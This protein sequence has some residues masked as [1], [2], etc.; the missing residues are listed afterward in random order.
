[1]T[2]FGSYAK[3]YIESPT[4]RI[5][6]VHWP[7]KQP[8][9]LGSLTL[10]Y[11]GVYGGLIETAHSGRGIGIRSQPVDVIPGHST[12]YW[13]DPSNTAPY[14]GT[15]GHYY[16]QLAVGGL[17]PG[18]YGYAAD[19]PSLIF[20]VDFSVT[21]NVGTFDIKALSVPVI[22]LV[23]DSYYLTIGIFSWTSVLDAVFA[24]GRQDGFLYNSYAI[25]APADHIYLLVES[26]TK[27]TVNL[28]YSP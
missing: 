28:L 18:Y 22:D 16:P 27:V 19:D 17:A 3:P 5:I 20:Q 10:E 12:W 21:T 4:G 13:S 26:P 11:S 15:A 9:F 23:A 6:E 25:E 2:G 8:A 14:D 7:T 24:I 1:M